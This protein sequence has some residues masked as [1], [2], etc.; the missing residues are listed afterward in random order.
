[1]PNLFISFSTAS[2]HLLLG[3]PLFWPALAV[4]FHKS[5][6]ICPTPNIIFDFF[7]FCSSLSSFFIQR[8]IKYTFFITFLS[9]FKNILC[10]LIGALFY[11]L[12]FMEKFSSSSCF[13]KN[14]VSFFFAPYNYFAFNYTPSTQFLSSL[15]FSSTLL[16]NLPLTVSFFCIW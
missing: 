12:H 10:Y 4:R 8:I 6:Y 15:L 5:L 9:Y 11:F 14:A 7:F 2:I 13:W 16:R 3:L 1:M